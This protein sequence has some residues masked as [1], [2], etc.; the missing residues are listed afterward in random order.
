MPIMIDP[1]ADEQGDDEQFCSDCF[2][3]MES[4]EHHEKCELPVRLLEDIAAVLHEIYDPAGALIW[5]SAR[6]TYLDNKRPCDIWRDRDMV[7]LERIC[8][9]LNALADGAFA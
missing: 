9:R 1:P 6:I 4:S 7:L 2:A 3:G 8:Q 5:W